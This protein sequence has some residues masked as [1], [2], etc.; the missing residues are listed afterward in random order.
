M[1]DNF[2]KFSNDKSNIKTIMNIFICNYDSIDN[3]ISSL[4]I[5]ESI[6][7]PTS[8]KISSSSSVGLGY[9]ILLDLNL[10]K[11]ENF[12]KSILDKFPETPLIVLSEVNIDID[13]EVAIG[14]HQD[15]SLIKPGR[16]FEE[17]IS[18]NKRGIFII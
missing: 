11:S 16:Y 1:I 8:L 17:L 5:F 14:E 6:N 18:K 7:F 4:N 3:F 12:T 10:K 13:Y 9:Q 15:E 2:K